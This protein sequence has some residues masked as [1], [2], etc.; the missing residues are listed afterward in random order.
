[1]KLVMWMSNKLPNARKYDKRITI[2]EFAT[3]VDEEG[4]ATREWVD[5]I[6]LWAF[7]KSMSSRWKE[8]FQAGGHNAERMTQFELRYREGIDTSMRIMFKGNLFEIVSVSEDPHG[9]KTETWLF[10]KEITNG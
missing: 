7:S 9:D 3:T 6:T 10:A 1:M 2:Q 5:L 8:Y 4:I